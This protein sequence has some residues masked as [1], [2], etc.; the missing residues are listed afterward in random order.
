[1]IDQLPLLEYILVN[2]KSDESYT[3]LSPD[4]RAGHVVNNPAGTFK[5]PKFG[6]QACRD[7]DAY[8]NDND[9]HRTL[10]LANSSFGIFVFYLHL[11]CKERPRWPF[12]LKSLVLTHLPLSFNLSLERLYLVLEPFNF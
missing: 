10:G 9:D 1:M 5:Y 4:D 7:V 8:V 2:C 12:F 11:T 3:H 6:D